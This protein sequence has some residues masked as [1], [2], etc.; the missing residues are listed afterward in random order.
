M[1]IFFLGFCFGVTTVTL[2]MGFF[3]GSKGID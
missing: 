3:I 1:L 2:I